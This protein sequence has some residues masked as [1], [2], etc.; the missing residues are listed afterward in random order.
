MLLD[1]WRIFECEGVIRVFNVVWKMMDKMI[2]Q[3]GEA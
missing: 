1:Y 2:D 3:G